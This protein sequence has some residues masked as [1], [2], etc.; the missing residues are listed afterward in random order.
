MFGPALRGDYL[1]LLERAVDAAAEAEVEAYG[2]AALAEDMERI[3]RQLDRLQAQQARRLRVFH[4]RGGAR[5]QNHESTI[6]WQRA[7]LR[8]SSFAAQEL[9]T[10]AKQLEE[11]PEAEAAFQAGEMSYENARIMARTAAAVGGEKYREGEELMVRYAREFSPYHFRLL[12]ERVIHMLNPEGALAT[13]NECYERRWLKIAPML[14]GMFALNGLLDAEGAAVLQSALDPLMKPGKQGEDGRGVRQRRADALVELAS[15]QL[16]GG[17]LPVRGGRKPQLTVIAREGQAGHLD[18][19]GIVPQ[20]TIRRIECDCE[21][22]SIRVDAEGNVVEVRT[23]RTFSARDRRL[24]QA[25]DGS[26]CAFPTGCETPAA[27]SDGHHL[28]YWIDGGGTD[29]DNGALLCRRHHRLVHEGGWKLKRGPD[30]RLV[31]IP[32]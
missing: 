21:K 11:L 14:D 24:M 4:R 32:P 17:G 8:Q 1:A 19:A 3:Q 31:A 6:G 13:A 15:R 18:W 12:N 16:A 5:S 30:G 2:D 25:R 22:T 7:R 28:R 9:L 27:W 10:V 20:E 26:T 23:K 29:P